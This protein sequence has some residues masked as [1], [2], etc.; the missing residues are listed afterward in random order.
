MVN[1]RNS[2]FVV[3]I[4]SSIHYA[5]ITSLDIGITSMNHKFPSFDIR[6][7]FDYATNTSLDFGIMSSVWIPRNA[8]QFR[9]EVKQKL[10]ENDFTSIFNVLI[11]QTKE[12]IWWAHGVQEYLDQFYNYNVENLAF[13]LSFFS[14]NRLARQIYWCIYTSKLVVYFLIFLKN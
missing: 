9:P 13:N 12:R 1:C 14:L 4:R 8:L 3:E 6:S 7:R 11:F 5:A 10:K 2:N